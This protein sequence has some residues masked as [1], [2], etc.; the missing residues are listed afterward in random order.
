[1]CVYIY[2]Y[3][4]ICIITVLAREQV[5]RIVRGNRNRKM[6]AGMKAEIHKADKVAH[7]NSSSS[8]LYYSR[9]QSWVIQKFM[10]LQY[11]PS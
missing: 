9:A 10:S 5:Q 4:Y 8:L 1:M 2:I 7:P 11:E 3:I 6:V